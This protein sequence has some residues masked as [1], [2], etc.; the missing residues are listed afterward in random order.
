MK[1]NIYWI[2]NQ[3]PSRLG[4]MPRP[5]GGD[6]LDDE[7]QSLWE[8]G[9]D[10]LI[11]LLT[12]EEVAEMYL[13]EEPALCAA[14]GLQFLSFPIPDRAVPDSHETFLK[15]STAL[16]R[17]YSQGRSIVI[18]CRAGIGRASL[19]AAYVLA[20]QGSTVEDA[21]KTIAAA[22]GCDVPDTPEQSAWLVEFFRNRKR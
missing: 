22:R 21:F 7:I 19:V 14:A 16:N 8:Q 1:C 5:R 9:V 11:S 18:H 12:P 2:R 3:E 13:D 15:F 10:V 6:W 4:I 17:L 20:L